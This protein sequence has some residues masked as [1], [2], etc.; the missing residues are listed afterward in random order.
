MSGVVPGID[1]FSL[2]TRMTPE[3]ALAPHQP[4][5]QMTRLWPSPLHA[6]PF[7]AGPARVAQDKHHSARKQEDAGRSRQRRQNRRGEDQQRTEPQL[8]D[9]ENGGTD[10][11]HDWHVSPMYWDGRTVQIGDRDPRPCRHGNSGMNKA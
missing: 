6:R 7:A 3:R 4:I 10:G 8:N 1:A 5:D 2:A 11:V 9:A